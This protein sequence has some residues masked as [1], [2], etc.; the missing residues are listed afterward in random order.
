MYD[1]AFKDYIEKYKMINHQD[2]IVIY[3][4]NNVKN[5]ENDVFTFCALIDKNK[6]SENDYMKKC[7]WGFTVDSFGKSGFG[8]FGWEEDK[9]SCYFM[10]E[11]NMK[12]LNI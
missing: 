7:D 1:I 5:F 3:D 12:N 9:K 11:L 6:I 8:S 4:K 2:W 10:M